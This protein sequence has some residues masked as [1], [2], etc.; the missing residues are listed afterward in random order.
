[1]DIANLGQDVETGGC[2]SEYCE[3]RHPRQCFY[4][5]VYGKC[6]FGEYCRYNHVSIVHD[7]NFSD[8]ESRLGMIEKETSWS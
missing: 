3:Q 5:N 6:K 7:D 4:Y 2:V 1:M 8:I